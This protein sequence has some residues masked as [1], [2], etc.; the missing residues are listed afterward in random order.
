MLLRDDVLERLGSI[1]RNMYQ[2]DEIEPPAKEEPVK[3]R[4]ALPK[5]EPT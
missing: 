1:E 4:K 5:A 3:V 2:P